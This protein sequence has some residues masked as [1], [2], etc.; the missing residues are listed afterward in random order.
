MSK[1]KNNNGYTF[2]EIIIAVA[3]FAFVMT[4]AL[5]IFQSVNRS[6]KSAMAAQTIQENLRYALEVMSKEIRQAARSDTSCWASAQNRVYNQGTIGSNNNVLFF[7]KIKEDASGNNH[8]ICVAYYLDNDRIKIRRNEMDS[9]HNVINSSAYNADGYITAGDIKI[10]SFNF[11]IFDNLIAALPEN[12][13]QPRVNL[14]IKAEMKNGQPAYAQI[15]FVQT[16][17]SSRNYGDQIY[18]N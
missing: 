14:K 6:Q 10:D 11:S 16:T 17:I 18:G 9:T 12:K 4:I 8:E 3:L 2:I 15:V 13:F 1:I 5:N 7:K